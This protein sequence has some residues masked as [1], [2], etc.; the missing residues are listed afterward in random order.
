MH[1]AAGVPELRRDPGARRAVSP[2]SSRDSP[3]QRRRAAQRR[4]LHRDELRAD[5]RRTRAAT[6]TGYLPAELRARVRALAKL[7][8][9][10]SEVE[11][12]L[13][14]TLRSIG[15][16]VIS[17]DASA[18]IHFMNPVA[19]AL[20]GWA[21]DDALS[22]PI[23]EVFR[24]VDEGTRAAVESP[25]EQVLRNGE[26]ASLAN[27]TLLVRRDGSTVAIDDSAAP[28]FNDER[29]LSGVVLVFRDVTSRR[30]D[31]ALRRELLDRAERAQAEAQRS[32]ERLRRAVEA[33]GAGLWDLDATTGDIDA[34]PRMVELMGL[35]A[36]APMLVT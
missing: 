7:K 10:S 23:A 2:C 22:R 16:A 19:V 20:T 5:D 26:P 18:H 28:L 6:W 11:A 27:H 35:P 15:D 4:R 33:S 34:D 14:T 30:R 9:R 13:A 1:Q 31:E 21:E 25:V 17:T 24:I 8:R 29:Q 32:E 36:L 3:R 12:R